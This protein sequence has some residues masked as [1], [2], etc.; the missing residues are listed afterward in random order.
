MIET[1]RRPPPLTVLLGLLAASTAWAIVARAD[2]VTLK[3]GLVYRGTVDRDNTI[4][5]VYDGLKRVV[6]R[7]SK[8]AR[9][10]SDASFSSLVSF[11]IEQPLVVHGG[12]MPKEV[13]SV[14]ASPWNDRGRRTFAY[15]GAR[16]GKLVR[17]EQAINELGPYM[18]KVRG[19]DG[20]WQGTLATRQIPREIVLGI[21]GK[22]ERGE[23]NERIKVARFLIQAE[24]YVEARTE[25]DQI[26]RD[27]PDD[28]DLAGRI[29]AARASVVQLEAE[30]TKADI[31]RCKAARQFKQAANLVKTFPSKDVP[32]ELLAQ[33]R[34]IERA[35]DAQ[36][37]ADKALADDLRADGASMLKAAKAT[38]EGP[39]LEVLQAM[40]LAP[41]AV[42]D[43]LV[44]YQKAKHDGAKASDVLFALAM[45]G[46]V[47][48]ADAAVEDLEAAASFWAMRDQVRLYLSSRD[49][50]VRE[51]LLASLEAV[52]LPADASTPVAVKRLDVVTRL[53]Q[54]MVPP[55]HEDESLKRS[56]PV[57]HRVRDDEN[58]EPTEYVV[59]LPPEYHPLRSYPAIVALHDGTDPQAAIS[60]WSA[61]AARRGYIVV[62]PEYRLHKEGKEYL[63][64][65]SEHAAVEL[66]LRDARRRY[67]IDSD[68]VF[69]GG[70]LVGANMA[71]DFGLAH[72]DLFAGVVIVSGLPFKY[73]NRY[74]PHAERVPLYVALGD[75]AP[76]GNEVVFQQ[77]LKP[78]IGRAWDV[79]YLEYMK[80]GLED[81]PEEAPAALDWM[82]RRRRD[83]CPKAFDA[84]S[85]RASDNRFYGVVLREFQ[86][87]RTTAPEAVDPFG[88]NLNPATIK[89]KSS[90]LSN[91][92]IIQSS[93][94]KKF[95]VWLSPR[96][97][98]FKKRLEVR[99]NGRSFFK[100]LAKPAL[101][102]LLED[103]R[104][105]GDRQQVYW[106]KV[107]AG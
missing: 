48:G 75:L 89:V 37:A 7:D 54:R 83:P 19:V 63:Y 73:V 68:R 21:L 74:L 20:F 40:K 9:I 16:L 36:A 64:S 77:M 14:Q 46:Y 34:E 50:P 13:V 47:V 107:A 99:I 10:E 41:D 33:V 87:G 58:A 23:K 45:S 97:I 35:D 15:E 96:I 62:A 65:T 78:L 42:R 102:P 93:G 60:W 69:L 76:A 59:S 32:A 86:P 26:V 8:V 72:P 101:E 71:W 53:V 18:A 82:E 5:W 67:A 51:G 39:L 100:G 91:N 6:L 27:F 44:A 1:R 38:W 90:A 92:L 49:A 106:M 57:I 105:R 81:L 43:R 95:D 52:G 24:W 98:D 85:A 31:E 66:A 12:N 11:R 2:T 61:E 56:G 79:T 84:L 80:R 30:R 94:V 25:L 104:I 3:N 17:M 22:V 70:Q 55:L 4:L 28:A 29:A 103:F 88:K